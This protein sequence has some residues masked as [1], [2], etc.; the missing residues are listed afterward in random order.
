MKAFFVGL[1]PTFL[2]LTGVIGCIKSI[3]KLIHESKGVLELVISFVLAGAV[4]MYLVLRYGA[5]KDEKTPSDDRQGDSVQTV[6]DGEN[7]TGKTSVCIECGSEIAAGSK[8]CLNC[9]CRVCRR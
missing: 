9:G 1:C 6:S 7:E 8:F 2:G 5:K 3:H 4:V